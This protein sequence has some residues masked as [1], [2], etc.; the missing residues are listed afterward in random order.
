MKTEMKLA[1]GQWIP[2]CNAV[3]CRVSGHTHQMTPIGGMHAA[4]L[5]RA[6]NAILV[7]STREPTD[8][9]LT[10]LLSGRRVAVGP[11]GVAT[12]RAVYDGMVAS[13]AGR[14]PVR[15]TVCERA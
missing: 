3:F 5:G 11:T 12:L 9:E 7:A 14:L 6:E 8:D 15:V 10:R 2:D 1:N 4:Y 13:D